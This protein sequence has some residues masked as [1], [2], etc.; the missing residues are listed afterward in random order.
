[1]FFNSVSEQVLGTRSPFLFP[2]NYI[3]ANIPYVNLPTILVPPIVQWITG[4][5]DPS[6]DSNTL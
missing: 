1:M 6:S 4:I 3:K 5:T 2:M